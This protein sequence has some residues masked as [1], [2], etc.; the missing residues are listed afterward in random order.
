MIQFCIG[1]LDFGVIDNKGYTGDIGYADV[2][3]DKGPWNFT[4]RGLTSD[5]TPSNDGTDDKHAGY[6]FPC[7]GTIPEFTF[8]IGGVQIA[9]PG[10]YMKHS[11]L[12]DEP[13]LCFGGLQPSEG[14]SFNIVGTIAFKSAFVVFDPVSPK[15]GWA[16]KS[17]MI[18]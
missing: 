4:I 8:E 12:E 3:N 6:V 7:D 15:I 10:D 11:V 13:H 18:A 5:T 9:V 2:L 16:K 14:L 17:L 1:A